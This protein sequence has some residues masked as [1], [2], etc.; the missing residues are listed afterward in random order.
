MHDVGQ[1]ILHWVEHIGLMRQQRKEA[2]TKSAKHSMTIIGS[3]LQPGVCGPFSPLAVKHV[4]FPLSSREK[5]EKVNDPKCLLHFLDWG[6]LNDGHGGQS[7]QTDWC[8]GQS[9]FISFWHHSRTDV[10]PGVLHSCCVSWRRED[11]L[12]QDSSCCRYSDYIFLPGV[13]DENWVCLSLDTSWMLLIPVKD[14][15]SLLACRITASL[16]FLLGC[17]ASGSRLSERTN[18]G[19]R[20]CP[21]WKIK[22]IFL[23]SSSCQDLYMSPPCTLAISCC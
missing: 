6:T 11:F 23:L 14:N 15:Q 8:S 1:S 21:V 3:L 4:M 5:R 7:D 13:Q 17:W 20:I 10:T 9:E 18:H 16:S 2:K 19:W 12:F 22:A